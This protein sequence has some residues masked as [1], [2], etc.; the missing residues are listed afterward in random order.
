[1]P[2]SNKALGVAPR[3]SFLGIIIPTTE[4]ELLKKEIPTQ[5]AH[6]YK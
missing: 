2:L 3:F 5:S 4:N 6:F 1:M